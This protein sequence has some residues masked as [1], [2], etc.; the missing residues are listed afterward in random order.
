MQ[1]TAVVAR[2][3]LLVGLARLPQRLVGHDRDERVQPRVVGLDP[4]QALFGDANRREL[5]RPQ[6]AA[7][8]VR[9]SSC[10]C[11]AGSAIDR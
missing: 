10:V 7:E 2:G 1:R 9:W 8:L 3:E 6:A 4:A 11:D 5:A